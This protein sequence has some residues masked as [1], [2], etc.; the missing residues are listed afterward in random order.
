LRAQKRKQGEESRN[1]E[2][3]KE[4]DERKKKGKRRKSE[5]TGSSAEL[6]RIYRITRRDIAVD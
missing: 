4:N 3:N 2:R 1:R 6:V 5:A